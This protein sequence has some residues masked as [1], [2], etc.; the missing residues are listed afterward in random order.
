M[1][2]RSTPNQQVQGTRPAVAYGSLTRR[3]GCGCGTRRP[4][5]AE[6]WG[7]RRSLL[8]GFASL[9]KPKFRFWAIGPRCK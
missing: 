8:L 6:G 3:R 9:A 1:S 7:L 4:Y 2:T 5:N